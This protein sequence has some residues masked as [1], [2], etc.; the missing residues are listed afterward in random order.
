MAACFR[1]DLRR[2]RTAAG[3]KSCVAAVPGS[4]FYSNP[5]D[6]RTHL[7]FAFCKTDETL[8]AA[9]ERLAKLKAAT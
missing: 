8:Q 4:S 1:L 3:A 7:R 2:S 5:A 9:A 6:G